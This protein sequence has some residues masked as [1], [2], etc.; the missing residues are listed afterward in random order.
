MHFVGDLKDLKDPK[1]LD[2]VKYAVFGCGHR[3]W[4]NTYQKVPTFIDSTMELFGA[5]RLLARGEADAGGD[6]FFEHFDQWE[7]LLWPRLEEV[8]PSWEVILE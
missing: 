4:V 8:R 7:S 5:T 6:G 2:G 1:S 3:D